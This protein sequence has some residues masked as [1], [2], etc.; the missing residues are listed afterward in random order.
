MG[1]K[2]SPDFAQEV[3]KDF[4]WGMK[5]IEVYIDDIII[6]SHSQGPNV[7]TTRGSLMLP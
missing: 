6:F 3:M 2:Q 5:Y 4:L 7:P 1:V